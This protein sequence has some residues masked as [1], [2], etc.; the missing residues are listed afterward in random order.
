MYTTIRLRTGQLRKYRAM[1]DLTQDTALA[2]A[3]G[4]HRSSVSRTISGDA[5]LSAKFIAG[6]LAVF[7]HLSFEDL[8]ECVDIEDTDAA[9]AVAS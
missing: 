7:K 8:F 4:A 1:S 5:E 2:A 9:E 3:M 6:L